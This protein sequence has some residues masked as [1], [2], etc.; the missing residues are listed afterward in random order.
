[1]M[2]RDGKCIRIYKHALI[3]FGGNEYSYEED[4]MKTS[5]KTFYVSIE[6]DI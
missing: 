1:M 2:K 6:S 4:D 5:K 3:E